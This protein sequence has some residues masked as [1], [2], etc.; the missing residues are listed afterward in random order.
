[1][2]E[3]IFPDDINFLPNLTIGFVGAK[4]LDLPPSLY[5]KKIRDNRYQLQL[6]GLAID[7]HKRGL[8]HV[9]TNYVNY[10]ILGH[11]FMKKYYTVFN[12]Q[13]LL[14]PVVTLYDSKQADVIPSN[15]SGSTGIAIGAIIVGIL[16]VGALAA[17]LWAVNRSRKKANEE[18]RKESIPP[19][20][21]VREKPN[22][23]EV[24]EP[25]VTTTRPTLVAQ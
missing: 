5:L 6:A 13:N 3:C 7:P 16:V 17:C 22:I 19:I 18:A 25:L 4:F 14:H 11:P 2:P 9:T 15:D 24:R 20:N 1:M 8:V 12:Y 23:V 21:Y 10:V